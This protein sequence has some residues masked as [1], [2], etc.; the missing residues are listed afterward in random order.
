MSI[1]YTA[2]FRNSDFAA[3]LF[4]FAVTLPMHLAAFP[5][6]L[7]SHILLCM[8]FLFLFYTIVTSPS[9]IMHMLVDDGRRSDDVVKNCTVVQLNS[10]LVNVLEMS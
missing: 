1:V 2:A 5:I 4:H 9:V 3:A 6:P 8:S 7:E 10:C